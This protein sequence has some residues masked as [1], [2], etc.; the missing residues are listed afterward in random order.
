MRYFASEE[1][2]QLLA[3][4]R[5]EYDFVIL[6]SAPVLHV[7]D[8]VLLAKLCHYVIFV[9]EAGRVSGD[10]VAEAIRRFPEADRN[11]IYTLLTRVRFND[12]DKRDYYRGYA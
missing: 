12:L 10:L 5:N 11:K 4:S 9:V 3:L 6:D 2:R 1:F 8:P 7:A